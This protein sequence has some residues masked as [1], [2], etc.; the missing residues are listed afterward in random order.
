[1]FQKDICPAKLYAPI[2]ISGV[3]Q[4]LPLGVTPTMFVLVKQGFLFSF[5]SP[6]N[7]L[8]SNL[9]GINLVM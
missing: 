3:Y 4:I 7:L 5:N 6:D 1:V 9:H 8:E 2:Q